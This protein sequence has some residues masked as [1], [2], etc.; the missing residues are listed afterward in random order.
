MSLFSSNYQLTFM[1]CNIYKN[2]NIKQKNRAQQESEK[3][4][5]IN[6]IVKMKYALKKFR[7]CNILLDIQFYKFLNTFVVSVVV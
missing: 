1:I 5:I 6:N 4:K 2:C 7:Y 3:K